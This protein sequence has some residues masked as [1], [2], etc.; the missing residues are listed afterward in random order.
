MCHYSVHALTHLLTA[1]DYWSV[2][3]SALPRRTRWT[4]SNGT[5]ALGEG[6]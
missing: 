1:C 2:L 5:T 4:L 6:Q 3:R